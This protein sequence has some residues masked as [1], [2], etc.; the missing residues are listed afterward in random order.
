MSPTWSL[1]EH[2]C[3]N[4]MLSK[5]TLKDLS[6]GKYAVIVLKNA[7][8][9]NQLSNIK[10]CLDKLT[11]KIETQVYVNGALT[12]F[13]PYL[14][15]YLNNLDG[16]FNA[17]SATDELFGSDS[18]SDLR[19]YVRNHLRQTFNLN[20]LSVAKENNNLTYSPA[21]V[22]IHGKGVANPLHND[23]IM[24]DAANTNLILRNL[25]VQLSCIVCIQECNGGGELKHYQKLWKLSDEIHKIPNGLGY[26]QDVITD[27]NS[28]TFK[29]ATGDIYLINPTY[30]HEIFKVADQDR[31]TMGFFMGFFDYSF[32]EGIVWS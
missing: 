17:A 3:N 5:E 21:V 18:E 15:K 25:L 22:R 20:S 12:T 14:A 31:I 28:Y 11:A 13:G 30:Y 32:D 24:R 10:K 9:K 29:P 19:L 2:D 7:L 23:N 8:K 27:A 4:G 26:K 16:Y 1:F 6:D